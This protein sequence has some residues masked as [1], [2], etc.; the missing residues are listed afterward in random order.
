MTRCAA[1]NRPLKLPESIAAGM[2]PGCLRKSVRAS[3]GPDL[4]AQVRQVAIE[5]LK[6]AASE[7]AAL[8]VK[9]Q[10]TIEE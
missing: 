3:A 9:F 10:L 1:C 6:A 5:T 8:G 4:F 7:C 2:G